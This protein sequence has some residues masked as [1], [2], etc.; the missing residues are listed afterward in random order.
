MKISFFKTYKPRTFNHVNIYYDPDKE[1]REE[2]ENRIINEL[3]IRPEDQ[4]FR[5]SIKRGSFRRYRQ[6]GE[7]A[8]SSSV[9]EERTKSSIRVAM[10]V[11]V[12]IV[13]AYALY[14]SSSDYLAL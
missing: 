9:R 7:P 12:L 13:I 3:G 14:V 11:M 8:P 5:T 1:E 2:R 10:I 6:G 4:P